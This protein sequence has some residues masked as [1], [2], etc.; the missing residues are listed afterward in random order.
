MTSNAEEECYCECVDCS[1]CVY[2]CYTEISDSSDDDECNCSCDDGSC[3]GYYGRNNISHDNEDFDKD[4]IN[5]TGNYDTPEP[6][7][8]ENNIPQ[9]CEKIFSQ[10]PGEPCSIRLFLDETIAPMVS[11]NDYAQYTFEILVQILIGGIAILFGTDE[12]GKVSLGKIT[13]QQFQLLRRYFQMLEYDINLQFFPKDNAESFVFDPTDF[14]TIHLRF[15]KELDDKAE[16]I[17][18]INFTP[19]SLPDIPMHQLVNM[20]TSQPDSFF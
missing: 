13:E 18:D 5:P 3:D 10:D 4:Y 17:I 14:T 9:L 1:Q 2:C 19:Y 7:P 15:L 6:N 20:T 12:S 8:E 11:K 16:V